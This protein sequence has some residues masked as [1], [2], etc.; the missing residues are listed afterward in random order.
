VDTLLG[1]EPWQSGG[2]IWVVLYRRL[3]CGFVVVGDNG[4]EVYQSEKLWNDYYGGD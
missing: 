4:T 2:N 3:D 1:A